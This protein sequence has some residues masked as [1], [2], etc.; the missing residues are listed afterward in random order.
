MKALIL[1]AGLGTRLR[2]LTNVLPKP[3]CLFF[4][5]P[6]L[7]LVYRQIRKAGIDEVAINTHHLA[8][9]IDQHI[10][11]HK[12]VYT[13]APIQSYE[14]EIL[15]TGGAINPL[16]PWLAHESLLICNGDIIADVDLG[17]LIKAHEGSG[18]DAT[19][20]LLDR[21][22]AGTTPVAYE[23]ANVRSIGDL[24]VLAP[25]ASMK[26]TFSG[27]HIVGPRLVQAI[28]A[29][30]SPSIIDAY[31]QIL[32]EGG[33]VQAFIHR[34][35][36]EDLGTPKD[37]FAAHL[38]VFDHPQRDPL[39]RSLGLGS[40]IIWDTLRRSAYCGEGPFPK[41]ALNSFV[42]GPVHIAAPIQSCLVYPHVMI[43]PGHTQANR[44]LSVDTAMDIV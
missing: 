19:M 23:E 11:T 13:K 9:M 16:R 42:F 29:Q 26:A 28:R 38:A 8:E 31:R 4:A 40:E 2:P 20:V 22:K 27:I 43:K 33:S 5:E 39:C 21:L 12:H 37:Y 15:G 10:Q 34:G 18:A 41:D 36:W 44:I 3:L 14:P 32:A 17:D 1:A 25:L 7:D 35:F 6:M 24:P 30:G